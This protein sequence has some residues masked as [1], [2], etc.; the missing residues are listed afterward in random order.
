MT[1]TV[2]LTGATGFLGGHVLNA[3]L[4]RGYR[5]AVTQ[6][7]SSDTSGIPE[8]V[9]TFDIEREDPG[10]IL[11]REDVRAVIHLACNQGR[12]VSA[13]E[14]L[15]GTNVLLGLRL[16]EAARNAQVRQFLNADTLLEPGVN[17]Y[18]LS[19]TQFRQWLPYFS[20][21]LAIANMRLGNLYGPGEPEAGFLAWLLREF[22]RDAQTIEFTAGE[23]RRDFVHVSDVSEAILTILE[24]PAANGLQEYD[25]GSGE[26]LSLRQFVEMARAVYAEEAGEVK[27]RLVFG[28]LPYRTGEVM[29]PTFD[30]A[31]LF[32]LGWRPSL[33]TREGLR[34]TI[35]AHL[36]VDG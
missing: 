20:D 2:L 4:A 22:G 3:L 8:H 10:S 35:R 5:V 26:M 15:V 13:I 23:Q 32:D 21:T 19:K 30:T 1:E 18:A 12:G 11:R 7:S 16:L 28:A 34:R 17:A 27:S 9:P 24:A 31:G 14:T 25:V 36:R 33:T 6:R 29:M